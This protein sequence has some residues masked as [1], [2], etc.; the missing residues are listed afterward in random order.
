MFEGVLS[1]LSD[2][3]LN[4]LGQLAFVADIDLQ[5][6]GSTVDQFGLFFYDDLLGLTSVARTGDA[7]DGSTITDLRFTSGFSLQ[8]EGSGLNDLG[9]VAY[10]YSLADGRS[11]VAVWTIPEPGVAMTGLALLSLATLRRRAASA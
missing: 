2:P 6:G 8:D 5:D 11:G 3:A 1:S 7:F 10:A 4:D 9:Q